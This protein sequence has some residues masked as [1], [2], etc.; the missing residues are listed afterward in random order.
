MPMIVREP[1]DLSQTVENWRTMG[2]RV[3]LVP[4]MG[5]LHEG[6]LTLVRRAFDVADKVVVTIF[7]NPK[8]FAENE[9][10]SKY[11]RNEE[12]DSDLLAIEGVDLIYAPTASAI[13]S[14][15]FATTIS[16]AGPA[17]A[18]LEDKFRPHFFDGVAT[19]VAK[20]FIQSGAD[21]ALF[22]EKD[23]QQLLVVRQMARDLDLPIEVMGVPTVRDG[24]GMALSSRNQYLSKHER[25]QSAALHR[26]LQQAAEKIRNGTDQQVA[27]RAAG[28]SLM[29]LG[30]K[31][32]YVTARNAETLALPQSTTEPL[33]LLVA[34]W[35]GTTRLIDN[36]AV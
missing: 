23:Y 8:Q 32:D 17:K 13:Y 35:M 28:R 25:H 33:R 21:V 12:V 36:I 22:G 20:L 19:V 16:V 4:T 15:T 7:V 30:F 31:V 9:D 3:A 1:S 2:K 5:A 34:A 26:T 6:H 10:L 27:T 29:T 24:D 11:P 14:E 18:G